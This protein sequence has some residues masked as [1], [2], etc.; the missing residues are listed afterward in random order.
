MPTLIA[1]S[2]DSG[3]AD[4]LRQYRVM[5]D[6]AEIGRISNG[7]SAEFPA[8]PGAH[9]LVLKVDWC[10]SNEVRF[11]I[12]TGQVLRFGCGSSLRGLRLFLA[13]YY[14]LFARERYLWLRQN[15][16]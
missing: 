16:T 11:S 15:G 12:G 8:S 2:R 3:Y 6:G 4:R 1:I 10:S 14:V 5:C 7:E 9:S 13:I